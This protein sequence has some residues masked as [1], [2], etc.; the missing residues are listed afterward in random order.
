MDI[1]RSCAAGDLRIS[2]LSVVALLLLMPC[3]AGADPGLDPFRT[4]AALNGRTR[5]LTDPAGRGCSQQSGALTLPNAEMAAWFRKTRSAL[6]HSDGLNV[7]DGPAILAILA[8]LESGK[9]RVEDMGAVNRWPLRSGV[10]LETYLDLWEK[11]CGEIRA[12]GQ[13]PARLRTML[14]LG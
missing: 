4:G 6:E 12:P 8:E 13:L 1:V 3:T 7:I 5:G 2:H 9:A 11:S 10:A 14:E